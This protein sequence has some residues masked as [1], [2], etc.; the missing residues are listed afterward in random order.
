MVN[1]HKETAMGYTQYTQVAVV[2]TVPHDEEMNVRKSPEFMEFE[3]AMSKL[4][5]RRSIDSYWTL[6]TKEESFDKELECSGK[7]DLAWMS[8]MIT[9]LFRQ[10]Q[11]RVDKDQE[12]QRL[13]EDAAK[14]K[15]LVATMGIKEDN[16]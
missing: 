4:L 11:H 12:I 13:R 6:A 15:R 9:M 3:D 2:I 1:Q 8:R 14:W 7:H 16:Q 10:A 5:D